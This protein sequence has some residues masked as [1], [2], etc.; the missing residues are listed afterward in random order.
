MCYGDSNTYGVKPDG[1]GRHAYGVRWPTLLQELLGTEEYHIIE[2]GY[3]GRTTVFDDPFIPWCNGLKGMEVAIASQSPVDLIVINLG[4]NDCKTI[5]HAS[6]ESIVKGYRKI[7]DLAKTF[8]SCNSIAIPQFLVMS[9]IKAAPKLS[10]SIFTDFDENSVTKISAL[11]PL[12]EQFAF[13][14]HFGYFAASSVAVP[15]AD[16]LHMNGENH[17]KLAKALAPIVTTLV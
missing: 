4:T 5:F 10:H 6:A 17:Q 13:D 14:N 7:I 16:A 3:N 1:K 15:G 11:G 9:P 2:Q 8:C 12:L